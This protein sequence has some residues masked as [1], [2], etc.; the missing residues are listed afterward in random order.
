M[1]R[2]LPFDFQVQ[3]IND[4]TEI[5][6]TPLEGE[7]QTAYN[8]IENNIRPYLVQL[9]EA[10]CVASSYTVSSLT[11][12]YTRFVLKQE[13]KK[14]SDTNHYCDNK[15]YKMLICLH[16]LVTTAELIKE[17]GLT[18]AQGRRAGVFV[19]LCI[20]SLKIFTGKYQVTTFFFNIDWPKFFDTIRSFLS[21]SQI[22]I[23]ILCFLNSSSLLNYMPK[24]RYSI[25]RMLFCCFLLKTK[26]N[27]LNYQQGP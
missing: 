18:V 14:K 25:S 5:V 9:Q 8:Y 2:L 27:K 7:L 4:Y 21:L 6:N 11:E 12:D 16:V 10:G 26:L 24:H 3:D 13:E 20:L 23:F 1:H 19:F 15:K 17:C 22:F